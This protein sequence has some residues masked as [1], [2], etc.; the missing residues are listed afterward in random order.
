M[1]DLEIFFMYLLS[2][3]QMAGVLQKKNEF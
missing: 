3:S 2:K 1:K